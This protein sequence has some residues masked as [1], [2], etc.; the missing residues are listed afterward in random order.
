MSNALRLTVPI[1]KLD[2]ELGIVFGWAIVSK[3]DGADYYDLQ[4]HHIPESVM[5]KAVT[6]FMKNERVA[7]EM[8]DGGERG[9][10]VH[11]AVLT[12]DIAKSGG[13]TVTQTGW[14]VGVAPDAELLAKFKSGEVKE[15]SIG[16]EGVLEGVAKSIGKAAGDDGVERKVI[17]S[18]RLDE[19]SLVD[20][21][22]QEP[23]YAPVAKRDDRAAS[24]RV[25]K[26]G[27]LT[28]EADGHTH[29]LDDGFQAGC[30]TSARGSGGGWH[31]HPYVIDDGG[32]IT[33]G[34][35]DSHT[36]E[37][38]TAAAKRSPT[39]TPQEIPMTTDADRIKTLE[40][41]VAKYKAIAELPE[42]QRAHVAKL[43]PEAGA[44]YLAKSATE[45]QAAVEVVYKGAD[46][47]VFTAA[48]DS[49][50]VEYA[51]RA[52]A[53][54][55]EIEQ[56]KIEKRAETILKHLPGS[57]KVRA[58]MIKAVDGIADEAV[59]KAAHEALVAA[60]AAMAGSFV[61]KSIAPDG[62]ETLGAADE[63]KKMAEARAAAKGETVA[64]ATVWL[65]DNEPKAIELKKRADA[66]RKAAQRARA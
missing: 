66:E 2:D 27:V 45:R 41:E 40:T 48:D 49:R 38:A 5:A 35:A 50:L 20:K 7:K 37:V 46:G 9:K 33:I 39:T 34:A 13:I 44:V 63:L 30:T 61:R 10:V 26:N 54:T 56:A 16:G 14:F 19:L 28:L 22:A 8:H 43:S 21:G 59:R 3:R 65:L 51:K 57:L 64:K 29:L 58:A 31:D 25:T 12:T 53:Q 47:Q 4:G 55:V 52:D 60:D 62:T 11:S 6:E 18:L 42:A 17:T 24:V 1:E 15:F 32:A 23:A 36:H